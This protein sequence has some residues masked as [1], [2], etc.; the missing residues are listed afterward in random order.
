[1]FCFLKAVLIGTAHEGIFLYSAGATLY[2]E[3]PF[4]DLLGGED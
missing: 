1:M 3:I 4:T 2:K